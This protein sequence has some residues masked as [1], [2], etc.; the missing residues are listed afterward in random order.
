MKRTFNP[1]KPYIIYLFLFLYFVVLLSVVWRWALSSS[2]APCLFWW[3]RRSSSFK[4]ISHW[5]SSQ[6]CLLSMGC[7]SVRSGWLMEGT[8]PSCHPG[9]HSHFITL[10]SCHYILTVEYDHCCSDIA[11]LFSTNRDAFSYIYLQVS[12]WFTFV[13]G[14]CS[15][16]NIWWQL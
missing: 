1:P 8:L 7:F 12:G 9:I 4:W 10:M 3:K 2:L 11:T 13:G 5:R 6:Q 14:Q 16:D 15:T